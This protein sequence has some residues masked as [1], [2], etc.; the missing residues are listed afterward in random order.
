MQKVECVA[1][2][3]VNQLVAT[4]NQLDEQ[5]LA[6]DLAELSA[7]IPK[8]PLV[9]FF[10]FQQFA[11]NSKYLYL[12][13]SLSAR[14]YDVLWC[15]LSP[16]VARTLSEA[17]LPHLL[18]GEDIDETYTTML[19]A[20]VAVFSYDP[21]ECLG[22]SAALLGAL[23]GAATL[24]MWHGISL[25]RL[26]LQMFGHRE[27][28]A[29]AG[30]WANWVATSRADY[31]LSTSRHLDRQWVEAFG[32]RRVARAGMPRNEV[33]LR[34]PT[35]VERIG[36][37][38]PLRQESA[39]CSDDPAVLVVPTWQ[40][41]G[42]ARRIGREEILAAAEYGRTSGVDVFVK[43]HPRDQLAAEVAS[44]ET[45]RLHVLDAHVDVYPWLSRFSALITD[46]SSILFDYL[47]TGNPVLAIEMPPASRARFEPDYSLVPAGEYQTTFTTETLAST[48]EAALS[49]DGA[50][51]ERLAYSKLLFET[52][53]LTASDDLLQLIDSLVERSQ[54]R[55]VEVWRPGAP[56]GGRAW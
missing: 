8:R 40:R 6:R 21:L 29:M 24:Q 54:E 49:E 5:R 50:R 43:L 23:S 45:E 27:V 33:I 30:V 56:L 36:A 44:W 10:G 22:S 13:A 16:D 47:L 3:D 52:D 7:R 9:L 15:T 48:L 32:A 39:L 18:I 55:H 14:G 4:V 12:R 25:K 2:L 34:Q 38:L 17:K 53:P 42:V 11:D 20:A 26:Q 31:I 28:A 1:N 35:A 37:Q 19:Q 51:E 46:Y 41:G